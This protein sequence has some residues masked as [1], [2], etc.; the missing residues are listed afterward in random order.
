MEENKVGVFDG[1]RQMQEVTTTQSPEII[2]ADTVCYEANQAVKNA[3]QELGKAYFEANKN[4]SESEYFARVKQIQKCMDN[5]KLCHQYRLSLEG[6]TQC[7]KCGAVIT[8]DS[9]FCNKC[10]STM[11]QWDF[12]SLTGGVFQMGSASNIG[13]CPTCGKPLA[14]GAAFCE[15]CGTKVM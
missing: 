11:T 14:A 10:G 15:V 2:R 6:K 12:S 13:L 1:K 9:A 3:I 4:N 5:E 8:S 7:E